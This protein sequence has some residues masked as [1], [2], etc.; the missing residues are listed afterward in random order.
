MNV[1]TVRH[2]NMLNGVVVS[3]SKSQK[4]ELIIQGNDVDNV[5]Q[6]GE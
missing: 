5:S 1:Q 2:V 3:E 4:D 6:S